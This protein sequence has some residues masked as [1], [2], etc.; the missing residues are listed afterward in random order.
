MDGV[1]TADDDRVT[2]EVNFT[3]AKKYL[4]QFTADTFLERT[5]KYIKSDDSQLIWDGILTDDPNRG[6]R[7]E[8][9]I[10]NGGSYNLFNQPGGPGALADGESSICLGES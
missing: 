8:R 5:L 3:Y 6:S 2:G 7:V 4:G 10:R 9:Q 1:I